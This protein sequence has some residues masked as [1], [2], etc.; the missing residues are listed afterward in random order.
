MRS[1][2]TRVIRALYALETRVLR[3]HF[4]RVARDV[5]KARKHVWHVHAACTHCSGFAARFPGVWVGTSYSTLYDNKKWGDSL[6]LISKT[7]ISK[8]TL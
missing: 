7:F 2:N 6:G 8:S 5:I 1:Y 3:S 4:A